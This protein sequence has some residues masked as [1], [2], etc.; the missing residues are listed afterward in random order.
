MA[1]RVGRTDRASREL[2]NER[3][4]PALA[5]DAGGG[6]AW[7]E[8]GPRSADPGC[9]KRRSFTATRVLRER[10]A[11]KPDAR[12]PVESIAIRLSPPT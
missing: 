1:G 8:S 2:V 12:E 5:E 7:V 6:A 9:V 10:P 11:W 4:V 3:L